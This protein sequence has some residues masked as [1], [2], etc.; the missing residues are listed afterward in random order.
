M[1]LMPGSSEQLVNQWLDSEKVPQKVREAFRE[2]MAESYDREYDFI[3]CGDVMSSLLAE[4]VKLA[5]E[6]KSFTMSCETDEAFWLGRQI[7][8]ILQEWSW[9]KQRER[10]W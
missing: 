10:G 8:R 4:V 2:V 3:Q 1:I 5:K 7:E 6:G 9:L